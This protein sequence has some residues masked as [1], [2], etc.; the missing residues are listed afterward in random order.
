M[1]LAW[2]GPLFG[3]E[4]RLFPLAFEP[5]CPLNEYT[6]SAC[7]FQNTFISFCLIDFLLIEREEA[8]GNKHVG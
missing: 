1:T 4:S 3:P 6:C 5:L 2:K 7:I 8:L